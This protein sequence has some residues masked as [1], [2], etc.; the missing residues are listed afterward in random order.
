MLTDDCVKHE[1]LQL[2]DCE[3]KSPKN[4][5]V[6]NEV[7]L[8]RQ[9]VKTYQMKWISNK[10]VALLEVRGVSKV[11]SVGL[12]LNPRRSKSPLKRSEV[13]R[14][15]LFWKGVR[16]LLLDKIWREELKLAVGRCGKLGVE[17]SQARDEVE[18]PWSC[19]S[20]LSK[21]DL[22]TS[23]SEKDGYSFKEK[24]KGKG[25]HVEVARVKTEETKDSLWV[26]VKV[27]GLPFHLWS[28]EVFKSIRESCG[29]FIA[30]D[31][32][33]TFFSQL[34]WTR[35]LV[36]ASRKIMPGSL[37]RDGRSGDEGGGEARAGSSVGDVQIG[38]QYRRADAQVECGKRHRAAA[39]AGGRLASAG[40]WTLLWKWSS[41]PLKLSSTGGSRPACL[42]LTDEALLEE[43][44][45]GA[46]G[47]VE[48][49][50]GRIPLQV[51][52]IEDV[53]EIGGWNEPPWG[54][55]KEEGEMKD[56]AQAVLRS[57]VVAWVCRRK[58]S[59]RKFIPLEE[60]EEEN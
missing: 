31:E 49:A 29:G 18:G 33:T 40:V 36:K 41:L 13:K 32:E 22:G 44:S 39:G 17:E 57:L 2:I 43:A 8:N 9:V 14:K 37:Q 16:L 51:R 50:L 3:S 54:S 38:N 55:M 28:R 52:R 35:I 48:G 23:I 11:V 30:V 1:K 19:H 7:D 45:S 12:L 4:T 15:G 46:E 20:S 42:K 53:S 58:V 26:H 59:K 27:V 21:G 56:G 34:Q 6:D 5:E 47:S 24:G 25:V 60:D 10:M